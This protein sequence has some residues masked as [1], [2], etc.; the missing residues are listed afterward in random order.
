M[1][2][3]RIQVVAARNSLGVMPIALDQTRREWELGYR[4]LQEEA[5]ES[6]RGEAV[7]SEVNAV[8]AELRRRVGQTFTLA[9]LADAYSASEAWT[10]E[11]VEETQPASGW[12]RR[13]STVSDAA[14]HLYS[15]GAVDYAP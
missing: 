13:L 9:E 15:R 1:R 3:G 10:R 12:P 8:T 14:F 11:A 2:G 6:P 4:R 5:R 7:L